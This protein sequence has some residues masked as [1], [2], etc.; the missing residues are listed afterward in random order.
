MAD[1]WDDDDEWD[2]DDDDAIDAKLGI[3]KDESTNKDWED[4]EDLAVQEKAAEDKVRQVELKKKG[5]A[6]QA[7][8]LAEKEQQEELEIA[9]KAMELEAEMEA[10]MTPEERQLLERQRIEEADHALTDDLFGAVEK[11]S[12]TGSKEP[13]SAGDK[14]VMKD[15]KDHMKHARKVAECMKVRSFCVQ[16]GRIMS[17]FIRYGLARW[18]NIVLLVACLFISNHRRTERFSWRLSF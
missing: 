1:N 14:V 3:K 18:S 4:E 9:R 8:K 10:N 16:G 2:A 7:K 6:L 11:M 5:S 15:L 13:A 17:L 12:V